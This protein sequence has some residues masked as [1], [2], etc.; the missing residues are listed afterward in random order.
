MSVT[1]NIS[2]V[3]RKHR[4]RINDATRSTSR[5]PND[6]LYHLASNCFRD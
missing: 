3:A 1:V 4:R 6:E 2:N 5:L